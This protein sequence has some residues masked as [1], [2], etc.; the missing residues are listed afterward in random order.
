LLLLSLLLPFAIAGVALTIAVVVAVV[1][2][3]A[4]VVARGLPSATAEGRKLRNCAEER[5][6]AIFDAQGLALA[7]QRWRRRLVLRAPIVK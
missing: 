3:I 1:A 4:A 5:A 6:A 7:Y 2:P